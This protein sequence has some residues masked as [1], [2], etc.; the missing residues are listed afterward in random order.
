MEERGS[1]LDPEVQH[2]TPMNESPPI[3]ILD[4]STDTSNPHAKTDQTSTPLESARPESPAMHPLVDPP[5][6]SPRRASLKLSKDSKSV[7]LTSREALRTQLEA[8][9]KKPV[10]Y[11][12]SAKIKPPGPAA[13]SFPS[14]FGS[15]FFYKRSPGWFFW[16]PLI[17]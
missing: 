1:G 14:S 4:S 5:R 17:L 6:A 8:R 15:S 12:I 3:V 10:S 7:F 13:Y 16:F 9:Q 11:A 2:E